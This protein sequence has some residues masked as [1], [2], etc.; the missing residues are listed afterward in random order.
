ME[1]NSEW[2]SI[3]KNNS[4]VQTGKGCTLD[5]RNGQMLHGAR[6]NGTNL[7]TLQKQGLFFT[8]ADRSDSALIS[9]RFRTV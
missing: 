4:I 6:W 2:Q 3:G 7:R 9:F 8:H 1:R 5:K